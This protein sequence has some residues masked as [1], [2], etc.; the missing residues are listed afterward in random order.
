MAL[1]DRRT[2]RSR[3]DS[4]QTKAVLPN[5]IIENE[6]PDDSRKNTAQSSASSSTSL[7]VDLTR[8]SSLSRIL[9]LLS[10]TSPLSSRRR[11]SS[12]GLTTTTWRPPRQ[13]DALTAVDRGAWRQRFCRSE[14]WHQALQTLSILLRNTSLCLACVWCIAFCCSHGSIFASGAAAKQSDFEFLVGTAV[15]LHTLMYG[16]L[17]IANVSAL[18]PLQFTNRRQVPGSSKSYHRIATIGFCMARLIRHTF[19]DFAASLATL[20]ITLVLS[21]R[22]PKSFRQ[23]NPEYYASALCIHA[24]T[25]AGTIAVHRIFRDETVIRRQQSRHTSNLRRTNTSRWRGGVVYYWRMYARLFPMVLL[26]MCAGMYVRIASQYRVT[27][28][29]GVLWYTLGSLAI[30]FALKEIA[31]VAIVKQIIHDP[32]KIFIIVGLP[33]VLIDTQVRVMLQRKQST[34]YTL[35]WTFGMAVIEIAIRVSKVY[36]TRRQ[37]RRK[38]AALS[39]AAA[40]VPQI[41]RRSFLRLGERTDLVNFEQWKRQIL[42]FQIAESYASMTAEYIAI[43]CSTS[44]VFFYWNHPKYELSRLRGSPVTD[45]SSS[46]STELAAPWGHARA[47]VLQIVVELCVDYFACV[48]ETG[49]G[50]ES[51]LIQRHRRFLGLLFMSI[52][53]LNILISAVLYI[54]VK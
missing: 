17:L 33:T 12:P 29:L 1:S 19:A 36:Y 53:T 35:A 44:I 38:E 7:G 46:S 3:S 52:A 49:S 16:V 13:P 43:G 40:V 45:N 2:A 25:T 50:I 54:P 30:K 34:S 32:R 39:P 15:S 5:T 47:L 10:M 18:L 31:K 9:P 42:T 37:I 27:G 21:R 28:A 26:G 4:D 22:A 24:F 20:T 51:H 6:S 48:L 14:V 8:Q 11:S 23:L 41:V